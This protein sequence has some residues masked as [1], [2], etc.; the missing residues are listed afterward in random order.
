MIIEVLIKD[1][2]ST[3]V[4]DKTL[5]ELVEKLG[6]KSLWDIDARID[7]E[8]IK[9]VRENG[10]LEDGYLYYEDEGK[11]YKGTITI[12]EADTSRGWFIDNYDGAESIVQLDR[13]NSEINYYKASYYY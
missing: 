11:R 2:Y 4:P 3:F 9:Y 10:K 12:A 6:Y 5:S 13:K 7:S 8:I 1:S